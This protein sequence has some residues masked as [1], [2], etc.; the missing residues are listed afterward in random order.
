MKKLIISL[1]VLLVVTMTDSYAQLLPC[2]PDFYGNSYRMDENLNCPP[3]NSSMPYDVFIGYLALDSLSKYASYNEYE[4]FVERQVYN[5]TLRTMM[6]YIYKTDEYNPS[7]F[8][9]FMY[10]D[11]YSRGPIGDYHDGCIAE[12]LEESPSPVLDA[13]LIASFFIAQINVVSI[14]TH[15][16]TKAGVLQVLKGKGTFRLFDQDIEMKPGMFIFMPSDAPHSLSAEEDL[17]ILLCL[18]GGQK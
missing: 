9:N 5:D 17:A 11:E 2:L 15:T 10:H 13:S 8:L 6:R 18:T 3:Y 4:A 12:V 7:M 1:S 16:S 14:D